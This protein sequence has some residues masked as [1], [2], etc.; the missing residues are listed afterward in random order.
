MSAI[1]GVDVG[2]TF[3]DV[4]VFDSD[5]STRAA[6]AP[7]TPDAVGG[8]LAALEQVVDAS[9]V[10]ALSFGSTIATNALIERRLAR[11]GLLTTEGFRDT[12]EIRRLW[13]PYLFGHAWHRPP[14]I[15]PRRLRLEA[16]GR[17][18]WRGRELEPLSEG[19]VL[20]AAERFAALEVQAVAVAFLFSYLD[21]IHEHRAA[22]ILGERLGDGVPV[23]ISS[24]INPE[25]NEYERTSTTAIAAGLAPIVDRALAA[26][27]ARL[28]EA[29]LVPPPRIMKSNGGVMSVRAARKR[30]VELVKSGPA[31]GASAGAFLAARLG[32]PNLILIDI[33]GTTAD[34]SLI[35]DGRPARADHD[36]LE[37]DIPIR[38]PVVDIRS[39]GAGGGSIA[40][41]D[42]AG[43]LHVGPRSAGAMP[44]P[45]AYGHGGTEPTVTD[46]AVT[47]GLIDPGYFL[48]G[49]IKLDAAA[50]RASL[51]RVA[52]GLDYRVERTA[53]AVVHMAT[54]E[55]A[56]LVRKITVDRGLDPRAF[57]LV[58]FGGAGPLF[59][60]TLLDELGIRRGIV[61]PGAATLSAMG[62]AF[63]DVTFDYRRSELALVREMTSER[64]RR[65]FA[66]LLERARGDMSVEG[67]ADVELS[68]SIDL[69]YA[70]QWH[71]IE[72]AIAADGDLREA[73]AR[74][75]DAHDRLWGHRRRED[76]VEMTAV[77]VRA[78]SQ[79]PKPS[80]IAVA[81]RRD[82]QPKGRRIAAFFAT[83][84]IET[85]V[86]ERDALGAGF[87]IEGPVI[88]EEPQ[89]TIVVPPGQ[90]LHLHEQGDLVVLR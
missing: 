42:E 63:A 86:F 70:G 5:G 71:E 48:G 46:A 32:E 64:L 21:P 78:A 19:D 43:A 73:A 72:V 57:T 90:R 39:V 82:T 35:I 24:E 16:A 67:F 84:E 6:K 29:G 89:T 52:A 81:S 15:V 41:L 12:L 87:S 76:A 88:V 54:V 30:P 66:D 68:T 55:M 25:R 49:T 27:E 28:G 59:V 36:S 26:V 9:E 77:R 2:G 61:P 83:G 51:E 14:A 40:S 50:A 10:E 47:C 34:A 7:S 38:V 23:L 37:W 8:V 18:D 80:A 3:T 31:G 58:A 17:I 62:G 20:A 65:A 79:V 4:Y 22:E 13:R 74:F 33:G 56:A 75:E 85:P 44:G 69:R 11:V 1:V 45:A 53:A 60:G